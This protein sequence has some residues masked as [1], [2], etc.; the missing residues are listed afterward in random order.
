MEAGWLAEFAMQGGTNVIKK[1]S[2]STQ[3][4][5]KVGAENYT[6]YVNMER[7]LL[8]S[9]VR[10]HA[11]IYRLP[12]KKLAFMPEIYWFTGGTPVSRRV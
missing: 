10:E 7:Q 9:I 1:I 6:E 4:G 3:T 11:H 8:S 5:A 12:W 2:Q